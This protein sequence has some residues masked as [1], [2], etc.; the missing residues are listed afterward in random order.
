MNIQFFVKVMRN[1]NVETK[2]RAFFFFS[3]IENF[4]K[5]RI[6]VDPHASERG[7]YI[8]AAAAVTG[9]AKKGSR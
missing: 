4:I 5:S 3:N 2:I 8:R 7:V 6:D 1:E 9:I